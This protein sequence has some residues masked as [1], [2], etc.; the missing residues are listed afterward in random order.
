MSSR[1]LG[2]LGL[3]SA[4]FLLTACFDPPVQETLH[5][6]FFQNGAFAVSDKVELDLLK[7]GERNPALERRMF[8]L[9]REL[10][11]GLDPWARRFASVEPVSERL[12]WE[13]RLGV[14]ALAKRSAL[15]A[16]PAALRDLF[17]DTALS[18][19]YEVREDGVAEL[20]IVPGVPSQATRRQRKDMERA[21]NEWTAQIADYLAATADLYHWL[22]DNPGHERACLLELYGD[23]ID[24]ESVTESDAAQELSAEERRLLDRVEDAMEGVLAVLLIPE[25]QDR[26]LD[27]LSHLIYDPFP[28]PLTIQLPSNPL[29]IEG[30]EPSAEEDKAWA[31]DTP[32][33]WP[34]LRALNERWIAP[35]PVM[36]YVAHRG[37]DSEKL[38][39]NDLAQAPRQVVEPLPNS[40]EVRREIEQQLKPRSAIYRLVWQALPPAQADEA[41]FSW[42][43]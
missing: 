2:R 33:L 23:V 17:S 3:A 5:L 19:S 13:K 28:A 8:D 11:E 27:E 6:R 15:F 32:G 37:S 4:L 36:L 39:L 43:E 24:E 35:D 12:S 41:E 30:F 20:A 42:E 34:A 29:E 21:L 26:S 18:A 7:D 22:D 10:L 38:D 16:E 1:L 25:G 31:V 9:R 14:L 40:L